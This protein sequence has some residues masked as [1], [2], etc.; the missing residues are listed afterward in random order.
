MLSHIQHSQLPAGARPALI[1][2]HYFYETDDVVGN[3]ACGVAPE[4]N[5]TFTEYSITRLEIQPYSH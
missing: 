2:H 3:Y 5:Y 1:D 4:V